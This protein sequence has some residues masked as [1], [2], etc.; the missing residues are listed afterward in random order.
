MQ[1]MWTQGAVQGEDEEV[2]LAPALLMGMELWWADGLRFSGWCN[3][4]QGDTGSRGRE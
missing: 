1:G 4:R 3:L 2:L